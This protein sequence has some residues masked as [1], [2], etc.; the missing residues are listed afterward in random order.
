DLLLAVEIISSSSRTYDHVFKRQ[1]YADAG[2]PFLVLVD[3]ANDPISAVS[4]ELDG[5]EY[6]ESAR[7]NGGALT[8][9]RPFAVTVDLAGAGG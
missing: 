7:S 6:L 9:T 4:Y 2:V 5:A 3:P 8:L 1:L